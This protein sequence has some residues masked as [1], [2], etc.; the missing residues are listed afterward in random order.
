MHGG[1]KDLRSNAMKKEN[2]AAQVLHGYLLSE[3]L[4]LRL[5]QIRDNL[6]LMSDFVEAT[7]EEEEEELLQVK[8]SRLGWLFDSFGDQLEQVLQDVSWIQRNAQLPQRKH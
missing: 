8:R 5:E 3:A 4:H 2:D 1:L 6:Y 7:T